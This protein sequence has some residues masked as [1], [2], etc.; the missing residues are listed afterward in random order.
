MKKL[1]IILVLFFSTQT[2]CQTILHFENV[3]FDKKMNLAELSK[4]GDKIVVRSVFHICSFGNDYD[5]RDSLYNSIYLFMKNN[6]TLIFEISAHTDSQ[7]NDSYN[8]RYTSKVAIGLKDYFVKKGI[9]KKRI[10]AVGKGETQIL[11]ECKNDI[12]CPDEKHRENRRIEIKII[13][14][15]KS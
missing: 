14:I 3:D 7:G 12:K 15:K 11:N 9:T 5:Y 1:L 10:K 4:I 2:F 6:P 13:D 8:Q